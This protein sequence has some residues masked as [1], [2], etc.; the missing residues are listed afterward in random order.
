MVII[1]YD[2][3]TIKI[4]QN[5][6]LYEQVV[7]LIETRIITGEFQLG[8]QLPSESDLAVQYRVSRTVIREAMKTLKERGWVDSQVGK[9]T[10]IT[11]NVSRGVSTSIDLML[12]MNPAEGFTY[13]LEVRELLEPPIVAL[14]AKRATEEQIHSL[15]EA[16]QQMETAMD[17]PSKVDDF[18]DCDYAFHT[19]IAQASGNPLVPLI[20]QPVVALMREQQKFYLY[21]VKAAKPTAHKYHCLIMQAIEN[22]DPE[23]ARLHMFNH[24]RQVA[25]DMN[26]AQF[27]A[28]A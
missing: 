5:R 9:G 2:N 27:N 1:Q 16:V 4:P 24:I 14:A 21:Q 13:L 7:N 22:R 20:L 28:R 10:F 12:R 25:A 6:P 15:R 23:T 19:L 11:D 3:M 18:I 8:D 17:D 26:T